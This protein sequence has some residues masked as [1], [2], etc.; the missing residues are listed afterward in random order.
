VNAVTLRID[1]SALKGYGKPKKGGGGNSGGGSGGSGRGGN[2]GMIYD[3]LP[4][5]CMQLITCLLRESP[6][7][8][9]GY[10]GAHTVTDHP[11]FQGVHFEGLCNTNPGERV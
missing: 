11:Y 1:W 9:L 2:A 5:S 8:R 3:P 4:N 6:K 10:H 7:E